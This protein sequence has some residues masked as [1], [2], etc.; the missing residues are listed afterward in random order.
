MTE[1]EV[2][3]RIAV[4]SR[5]L[6]LFIAAFIIN[7]LVI[8]TFLTSSPNKS[9]A[10]VW[11]I[12]Y[13]KALYRLQIK[14]SVSIEEL[15]INSK[16]IS[17]EECIAC[18]GSMK[19]HKLPLHRIHL[20]SDIV[21]FSCNNCHK[22]IVLKKSKSQVVS[23]LVDVG[24]CKKC[25]SK[26]SGLNPKSA[27]KPQDFEAD[28]TMCHT[29]DH[30]P[31][32]SEEFLFPALIMSKKECKGCH[33]DR[34]LPWRPEHEKPTWID[35]HG[36]DALKIGVK[37]CMT[38]HEKGLNFC[39]ECHSK[40]P[41]SHKNKEKWLGSHMKKAQQETRAC[42]TCHESDFCKK[43]HINHTKDWQNRHFEVVIKDG[44]GACTNCH[45]LTFCESCHVRPKEAQ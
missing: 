19:K 33:G 12:A 34:V 44:V 25:H 20:N 23:S 32:H 7:V 40:K 42:F 26:F 35:I 30:E 37:K 17:R 29:G 38:C 45:S 27:M 16:N 8:T 13:N 5:L 21:N 11:K 4:R 43:C 22:K 36:M 15:H 31:K 10:S 28:C 18:H 14:P 1:D 39:Q 6:K 3:R 2:K 9:P 24:F 41:P